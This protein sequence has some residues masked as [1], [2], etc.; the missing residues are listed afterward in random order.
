MSPLYVRTSSKDG[1]L[2]GLGK[3][4][5]R[6]IAFQRCLNVLLYD[7]RMFAILGGVYTY[8]SRN[9]LSRGT[10]FVTFNLI[11]VPDGSE[12]AC[13][14]QLSEVPHVRDSVFCKHGLSAKE[15]DE[16]IAPTIGHLATHLGSESVAQCFDLPV[17]KVRAWAAHFTRGTY[18]DSS[19]PLLKER[20][21]SLFMDSDQNYKADLLDSLLPEHFALTEEEQR[22]IE[23]DL[24]DKREAQFG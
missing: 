23:E 22:R 6:A 17:G 15:S 21:G 19:V 8:H 20:K 12:S 16:C 18:E 4:A 2:N 10:P 7:F 5:M 13:H 3:G 1:K 11:V 14:R 24:V 9:K